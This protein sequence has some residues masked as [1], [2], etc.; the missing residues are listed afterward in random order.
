MFF[1]LWHLLVWNDRLQ[2]L[3]GN[4]FVTLEPGPS[5]LEDRKGNP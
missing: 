3:L 1:S 5:G 4:V 2:T